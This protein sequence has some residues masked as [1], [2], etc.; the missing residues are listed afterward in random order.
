MMKLKAGLVVGI[1]FRG[2]EEGTT[3]GL[4][5]PEWAVT[6]ANLTWPMNTNVAWAPTKGLKRDLARNS[7]AEETVKLGS[8]LLWFLDD[9]VQPPPDAARHLI[10]TIKQADDDVM[11]VGGIYCGKLDPP[12]PLVYVGGNGQGAHWKWKKGDIFECDSIATGC[13]MIKTEVFKHIEMPWFRDVDGETEG[14]TIENKA[15][16][17]ALNM[18]DDLWFCEKVRAAGFKILADTRVICTHWD[19]AAGKPY[20]LP[21]DSYPMRPREQLVTA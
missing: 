20:D 21:A 1:P 3:A 7:I 10:D 12:E 11:V 9:D 14:W 2:R 17:A 13:M 18:T 16:G 15:V 5:V 4:V 6:L 8:P 19:V